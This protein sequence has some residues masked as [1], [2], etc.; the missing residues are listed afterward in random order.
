[1]PAK[2]E[3]QA[4]AKPA[5]DIDPPACFYLGR[6][7]DLKTKEVGGNVMYEAHWL[8]TH[9]VVVGMTGSGKTG[10]C[11]SLLEEAALDSIPCI[12]VDLKGDLTNLFLQF[13]ELKPDD[14]KPWLDPE[15]AKR[16]KLTIDEMADKTAETWKNGLESWFQKPERIQRLK[17]CADWRIYTPGSEVARPVSI[18]QSF[19]APKGKLDREELN[20]RVESTTTALLGLTKIS[21]DPLQSK[22]HILVA[23][24]LLN[25]WSKGQDMDLTKVITQIQDPP[26]S[27]IGAFEV[28]TFFPQ[29]ERLKLAVSLNNI[30]ASPSFST[31]IMGEGLDFNKMLRS[32]E[33]KPRQNIFYL[34][35]LEE[36][37]RMFF[38]TLLLSEFLSWTRSQPGT[39]SLR[40]ILYV[41]EV[42]GYLP[43]HPGN[44]PSKQPFLTLLKQARAFGV[45]ILLATQNPVDLDYKAL[46][47]AGTWFVG[48][49]QTERDK[50][51]LLEGLQGAANAAGTIADKDKLDKTISSLGNRV[52]LMNCVHDSKQHIFQTRWALSY[53]AGPMTREQLKKLP[54]SVLKDEAPQAGSEPMKSSITLTKEGGCTEASCPASTFPPSTRFCGDCGGKLI[55]KKQAEEAD[56]KRDIQAQC[57]PAGSAEIASSAPILN[58]GVSQYYLKALPIAATPGQSAPSKLVYQPYLLGVGDASMTNARAGVV[59]DKTYRLIAEAPGAGMGTSWGEAQAVAEGFVTAPDAGDAAWLDLPKGLNDVKRMKDLSKEFADFVYTNA[60][61]TVYHNKSLSLTSEDGESHEDFLERCKKTAQEEAEKEMGD[62]VAKKA[63]KE[64]RTKKSAADMEKAKQDYNQMAQQG[65]SLLG[66]LFNWNRS[67]Q[68][69]AMKAEAGKRYYDAKGEF[70]AASKE[71]RD[72]TEKVGEIAE[73][74]KAKAFEELKEIKLTTKKTDIKVV[75]FGIAWVPYWKVGE[76]LIPAFAKG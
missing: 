36:S 19:S 53:L 29:A 50:A 69:E 34:A 42:F 7:Y 6:D 44:P 74:W 43:P 20:E 70:D 61:H 14:F 18:L 58:T 67:N 27:R 46:T 59:V 56:F 32:P 49:L 4:D 65:T 16:K 24:L 47:N 54:P 66:Q 60:N 28:D 15:V 30:L 23:N 26:I 51:R 2:T 35:H 5:I 72:L 63:D 48:K 39:N 21:G 37:Q 1:M 10:L 11:I 40:A 52:F 13:P 8:T 45:G 3:A 9:G 57:P 76:R 71:L 41:D 33:G 75:N 31:W 17:D 62:M 38:L 73:K 25:A 55:P 64:A 22:E 12:I 68:Q